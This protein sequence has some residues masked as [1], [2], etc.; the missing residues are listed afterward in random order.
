MEGHKGADAEHQEAEEARLEDEVASVTEADG[1]PVVLLQEEAALTEGEDEVDSQEW[2]PALVEEGVNDHSEPELRKTEETREYT[3]LRRRI[4]LLLVW[5]T[6]T[7]YTTWLP[8]TLECEM[9]AH[10][11]VP[12]TKYVS[13]SSS[14][15][16]NVDSGSESIVPED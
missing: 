9:R 8:M 6:H 11:T 16:A 7:L 13:S 15:T 4:V 5:K 12:M 2:G 3:Q 1:A 14:T 10:T